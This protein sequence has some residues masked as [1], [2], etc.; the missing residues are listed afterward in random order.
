MNPSITGPDLHALR[1]HLVQALAEFDRV[2]GGSPAGAP[3]PTA[4]TPPSPGDTPAVDPAVL[5]KLADQLGPAGACAAARSFAAALPGRCA[6]IERC[7][8]AVDQQA[9]LRATADLRTS[10]AMFGLTEVHDWATRAA[11][12]G[13]SLPNAELTELRSLGDD[14]ASALRRWAL[15]HDE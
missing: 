2:L 9:M 11:S 6:E 14:A 7:W 10:S 15:D 12:A 1:H 4:P 13:A 8:Y 3:P 5:T